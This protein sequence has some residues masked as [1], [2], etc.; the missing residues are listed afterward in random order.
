[1][2]CDESWIYCY[3]P[4]TKRYRTQLKQACS[5]RPKNGQTEKIY[6]QDCDY[7]FFE[8]SGKINMH[9]VPTR[10]TFNEEYYVVVSTEFRGR[11]RRKMPALLKSGQWHFHRDNA[12]VHNSIL[13]TDYLTKMGIKTVPHPPYSLK[14]ALCDFWVFP[15]LKEKLRDCRYETIEEM[16]DDDGHW[17]AHTRGLAW[18]LLEVGGTVQRV[19]WS[20]MRLFRRG[21]EFHVC[22]INKMPIRKKSGNLLCASCVSA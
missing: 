6:P 19:N 4:E 15:K 13:V 18:G 2:T 12:S 5:P 8:S 14:L 20:Q 11:F 16:K 1:M 21:L 22:T 3:D 7:P 9:W 10:Q 17:H